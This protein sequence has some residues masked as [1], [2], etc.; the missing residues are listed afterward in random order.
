MPA[1]DNPRRTRRSCWFRLEVYRVNVDE[2]LPLIDLLCD[3][4]AEPDSALQAA[5]LHG[6]FESVNRVDRARRSNRFAGGGGVGAQRGCSPAAC[7]CQRWG[8]P[9]GTQFGSGFW[10]CR[11]RSIVAGRRRKSRPI[12]PS[13]RPFSHDTAAPGCRGGHDE[14]V[15]LLVERGA[16]LNLKDVLWRATPA[17]WAR[18]AGRTEIEAYLRSKMGS[19]KREFIDP[20]APNGG[21]SG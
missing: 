12:Q 16:R 20:S 4:G 15:R 21:A 8:P 18:H 17:D 2:Q 13:R 5:V 1:Q 19:E 7:G 3:H 11:D 10:S 9:F 6:E 14:V